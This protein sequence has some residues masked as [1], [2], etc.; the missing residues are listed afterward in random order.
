MVMRLAS[1]HV[2][3]PTAD[4]ARG[5]VDGALVHGPVTLDRQLARRSGGAAVK[6]GM[7]IPTTM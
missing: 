5:G 3:A 2:L 1:E 6:P 7:L 4:R